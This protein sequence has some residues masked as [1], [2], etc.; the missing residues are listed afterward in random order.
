LTSRFAIVRSL[1]SAAPPIA[2]PPLP[3]ATAERLFE[4]WRNAGVLYCHWKSNEHV[5]DGMRGLTD[6]DVLVDR[7]QAIQAQAILGRCLFKRFAPVTGTGY[8]AIEDY[9]ALDRA[10]GRLLHCHL[11]FRLIAGEQHLKGYR[12]PWEDLFLEH[13]QWNPSAG[14]YV[15]DPHLEMLALLVRLVTKLRTRDIAAHLLGRP[16]LNDAY[17]REYQWLRERVDLERCA[18]F[19]DRLLGAPST[20]AFTA[21]LVSPPGLRGVLRFRRAARGE[22]DLLRSHG[23]VLGTLLRWLRTIPWLAAGLNRRALR[24]SVPLRR[25]LPTGGVL[26]AFLGA[27]GSGKS[28][29]ARATADLFAAKVDVLLTYFGSGDGPGSLVRW[30]LRVARTLALRVGLL[31]GDP[32][33]PPPSPGEPAPLRPR[34]RLLSA[35]RAV[36][37]LA[38]ALEK[39]R[40]LRAAWRARTLGMVVLTDRY[41]QSQ[42]LGFNDGPLLAHWADHRISSLRRLARWEGEPYRWAERHPPDVVIKLHVSPDT[43]LARKPETG[44]VEIVRRVAAIRALAFPRSAVVDLDADRPFPEVSLDVARTVWSHI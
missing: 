16:L 1:T 15:A 20:T 12:L 38:L 41:P 11:H 27:D 43:A 24:A 14:I 42:I 17:L 23:R 9:L 8:P 30:P 36:W 26:V 31:R 3:L 25:T 21:L 28:T 5:T 6:L 37:S 19:C 10:T 32:S 13:R 29:H 39:R 18:H 2:E 33:R 4:E 22:L 40:K 35:A 7:R 44:R 34:G